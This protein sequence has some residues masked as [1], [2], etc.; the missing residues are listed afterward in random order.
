METFA[1]SALW[2]MLGISVWVFMIDI[3]GR[4]VLTNFLIL[5]WSQ[6]PKGHGLLFRSWIRPQFRA[7]LIYKV[8]DKNFDA[9][10]SF[11]SFYV[12]LNRYY[13][14]ILIRCYYLVSSRL[15][16]KKLLLPRDIIDVSKMHH[17]LAKFPRHVSTK[18]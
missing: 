4:H 11:F 5:E 15:E 18:N 14:M 17:F 7:P 12:Y 1:G 9:N 6:R 10:R 2:A 3:P 16:I 13:S 8:L